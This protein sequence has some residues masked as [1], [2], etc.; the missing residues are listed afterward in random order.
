[1]QCGSAIVGGAVS[2][3]TMNCSHSAAVCDT[4]VNVSRVTNYTKTAKMGKNAVFDTEMT[5][6]TLTQ[7]TQAPPRAT[8]AR[9]LAAALSGPQ[10]Y[11]LFTPNV[12]TVARTLPQSRLVTT[13][14][15]TDDGRDEC[16]YRSLRTRA[17]TDAG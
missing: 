1:M 13:D 5:H 2:H 3:R 7:V 10:S 11:P 8:A 16:V 6:D 9:H 15:N 17:P 14:M 12:P 4:C